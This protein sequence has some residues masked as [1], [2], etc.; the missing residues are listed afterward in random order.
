M[1]DPKA[2]M[3]VKRICEQTLS[4]VLAW[5]ATSD[6]D[7]FQSTIAGYIVRFAA[8]DSDSGEVYILKLF[9]EDGELIDK[10]DDETLRREMSGQRVSWFNTMGKAY[11][12]ARRR[13]MGVDEALSEIIKELE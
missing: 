3:F 2:E 4:G 5:E 1:S 11:R 12:V 6:A 10:Y 7:V 9:N 13:A 8:E